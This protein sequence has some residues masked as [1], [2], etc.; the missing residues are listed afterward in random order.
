MVAPDLGLMR[1]VYEFIR[2]KFESA[3][4]FEVDKGTSQ[5]EIA[6][7]FFHGDYHTSLRHLD[8]LVRRGVVRR[9]TFLGLYRWVPSYAPGPRRRAAPAGRTPDRTEVT[10]RILKYVTDEFNEGKTGNRR[11]LPTTYDVAKA[12]MKGSNRTERCRMALVHLSRLVGRCEIIQVS[13]KDED[14]RYSFNRVYWAL[15]HSGLMAEDTDP[16]AEA[17]TLNRFDFTDEKWAAMKPWQRNLIRNIENAPVA[18]TS[19]A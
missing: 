6:A 12:C 11:R 4:E 8:A 1:P 17:A 3:D 19:W 10:E 7:E 13:A 16:K 15:P 18:S 2:E 5:D 14:P 9:T